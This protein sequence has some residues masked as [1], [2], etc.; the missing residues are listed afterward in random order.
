MWQRAQRMG[1]GTDGVGRFWC[2]ASFGMV[3]S[4]HFNDGLKDAFI[5]ISNQWQNVTSAAFH[6]HFRP[7]FVLL[8]LMSTWPSSFQVDLFRKFKDVCQGRQAASSCS[9][10][11]VSMMT[12]CTCASV[13]QN[14]WAFED[15]CA[16]SQ[17][18]HIAW[19]PRDTLRWNEAAERQ[20]GKIF[21]SNRSDVVCHKALGHIHI[22][23]HTVHS[24]IDIHTRMRPHA[25]ISLNRFQCA[26]FHIYDARRH[27]FTAVA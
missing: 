19:P 11:P 15:V 10:T 2:F 27:G 20:N 25:S 16:G 22:L 1:F 14:W 7:T 21:E 5:L 4:T 9:C 23:S 13:V 26:S 17:N 12:C 18:H 3:R 6:W 8:S 24:Y